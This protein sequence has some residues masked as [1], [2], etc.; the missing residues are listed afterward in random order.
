T[1]EKCTNPTYPHQNVR[2]GRDRCYKRSNKQ[3]DYIYAD[4]VDETSEETQ[5]CD[6]TITWYDNWWSNPNSYSF[7]GDAEALG[8]DGKCLNKVE[9][10]EANSAEVLAVTGQ[11]WEAQLQNFANWFTYYRRR[12]HAIRGGLGEAVE[13]LQN[14]RLG[15]F[16]MHN[17]RTVSML[18]S[19][20]QLAT[21]LDENYGRFGGNW[22]GGGTP[23]RLALNHAGLEF[24][25]LVAEDNALECRKNFALLFT[26]GYANN[27]P[28]SIDGV[29]NA[30]K[31][32]PQPFGSADGSENHS[33]TLGDIAYKYYQGLGVNGGAVRVPSECGT[34]DQ[35]AWMDCNTA[36][37]MNTYTVSF[38]VAGQKFAGI[39]HHKVM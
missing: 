10:R 19:D 31:N 28:K 23:T 27:H 21:F 17:R 38:G 4:Y 35:R 11:N 9:L 6:T 24:K 16:W 2:A 18:D 39:T 5:S 15:M 32:A 33:N 34:G 26:D 25:R 13:G 14:M 7:S 12:H 1:V 29:G 30:D 36:H 3:G 37:H 22:S 8:P 20:T